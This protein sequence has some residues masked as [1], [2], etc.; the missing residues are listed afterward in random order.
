M[1]GHE[2][3]EELNREL[4]TQFRG[5]FLK[6]LFWIPYC[7]LPLHF[8]LFFC[9]SVVT[10]SWF[11][12]VTHGLRIV[13]YGAIGAIFYAVTGSVRTA[14]G[15]IGRWCAAMGICVFFFAGSVISGCC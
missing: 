4:K 1:T 13:G 14:P 5:V 15:I 12:G 8:G 9:D 7:Y 11:E 3:D 10:C 6:S 2:P